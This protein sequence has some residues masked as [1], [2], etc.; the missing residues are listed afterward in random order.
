MLNQCTVFFISDR[1]GITAE[2]LGLS[3]ISQFENIQFS[4]ITLPFIDSIEKAYSAKKRIEEASENG[5]PLVF[6]TIINPDIHAILQQNSAYYIDFF[7]S[8]IPKLENEL[9]TSAA[10]IAGRSHGLT[11]TR[12]YNTRME[13]INYA[14]A[15]DDGA[16]TTE[17]HLANVILVGVSR[18]GKTPTSL[19]LAM[20]YGV[21]AANYPFTE[22]DLTQFGLPSLLKPFHK[23][24]FG[25]T[26]DPK[27]LHAIRESRKPNTQYAK[28]EQCKLEVKLVERIFENEQIPYLSSTN[29]SVEELATKL[30]SMIGLERQP[31]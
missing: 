4:H 19:Y 15:Y 8:F 11:N 30:M 10:H 3:L 31:H 1:T 27:R 5:R 26:I 12:A 20:Q 17:Y 22:E 13:A 14:L 28:L 29:L 23:K 16:K 24:L 18:C 6:A 7:K 9:K 21:R 2:T 25:L